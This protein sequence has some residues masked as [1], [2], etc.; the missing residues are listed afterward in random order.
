MMI[1]GR[2]ATLTEKPK[3]IPE[4]VEPTTHPLRDVWL[5]WGGKWDRTEEAVAWEDLVAIQFRQVLM[6]VCA[7]IESQ[8]RTFGA[9][10]KQRPRFN[11]N[12]MHSAMQRMTIITAQRVLR[13]TAL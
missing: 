13:A 7:S 9:M 6:L 11:M 12:L 3:H 5:L 2:I 8:V 1:D 4:P 10:R